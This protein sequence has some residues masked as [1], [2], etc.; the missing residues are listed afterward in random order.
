MKHTFEAFAYS[1]ND[2]EYRVFPLYKGESVWQAI[3]QMR[4]ARRNGERVINLIW[5][6]TNDR[7]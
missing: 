5:R 2:D 4:K 7:P 1:S 6:P 3:K